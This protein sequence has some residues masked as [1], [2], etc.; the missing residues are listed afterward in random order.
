MAG[1]GIREN[2]THLLTQVMCLLIVKHCLRT[3]C[4]WHWPVPHRLYASLHS[5]TGQAD[6][7]E[8]YKGCYCL[9]EA[10]LL[11][12]IQQSAHKNVLNE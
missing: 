4:R 3:D 9:L 5:H 7:S 12:G 2:K 6:I 10:V 1:K 8:T 11:P